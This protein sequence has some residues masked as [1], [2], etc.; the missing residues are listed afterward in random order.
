MAVEGREKIQIVFKAFHE[1]VDS[2]GALPY[3]ASPHGAQ[4]LTGTVA[5]GSI[6]SEG[7]CMGCAA[8]PWTGSVALKSSALCVPCAGEPSEWNAN[9]PPD[10]LAT[11]TNDGI[12]RGMKTLFEILEGKDRI[13]VC[14]LALDF[15]VLD[16]CTNAKALGFEHVAMIVD[17]ARA[18][19]IAGRGQY[20][21]GFLSDP[22]AL[23][24]GLLS[25]GVDMVSAVSLVPEEL[26]WSASNAPGSEVAAVH[27]PF[28][29]ELGSFTLATITRSGV[30][31]DF[32]ATPATYCLPLP[33]E[34]NTDRVAFGLIS[35]LGPLPPNGWEEA[36]VNGATHIVWAYPSVHDDRDADGGWVETT[37]TTPTT[38]S[39]AGS[40][41]DAAAG[42]AS[43]AAAGATAL[44][45]VSCVSDFAFLAVTRSALQR[46]ALYGG[47]ILLDEDR[48]VVGL[49]PII[50]E[51]KKRT[52][53]SSTTT[54]SDSGAT[55]SPPSLR[56]VSH[57]CHTLG[58]ARW[59]DPDGV[60]T[61]K[62]RSQGRF[63]RVTVPRLLRASE[64]CWIYPNEDVGKLA[65]VASW[66]P[67]KTGA[68][69]YLFSEDSRL[70][71]RFFPLA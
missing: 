7:A 33:S 49:Q 34:W 52:P 64:F 6:A 53:V 51:P 58:A 56:K 44:R 20:G 40:A 60:I 15:C 23:V 24:N 3:A 39:G 32:D 63:Q 70:T 38:P 30:T 42:D 66:K 2:F 61:A 26:I 8:A 62:L 35:P 43:A 17:L 28:P 71:A 55:V 4:R 36:K 65:G 47:F 54:D 22:K 31:I 25:A 37:P 29:Q 59:Q 57:L 19:H 50:Q 46:F 69:V 12:D 21:S 1:S 11:L 68:F 9:A 16:T 48:E 18:A 5:S 27:K 10:V 14:G 41:D 67:S 13:Y 45:S